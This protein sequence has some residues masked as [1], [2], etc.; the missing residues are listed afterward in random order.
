MQK[1]IE[2]EQA[3]AVMIEA[4]DGSVMKWLLEKKTVR[5]MADRADAALDATIVE[6]KG[7]SDKHLQAA[8]E[9]IGPLQPQGRKFPNCSRTSRAGWKIKTRCGGSQA[10]S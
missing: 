4:I 2:V 7:S 3:K 6:L 10:G 8:Y 5:T 1:L 9:Q